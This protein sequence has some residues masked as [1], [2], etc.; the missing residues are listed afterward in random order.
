MHAFRL[1]FEAC[2][3]KLL[4]DSWIWVTLISSGTGL[5]SGSNRVNRGA[6]SGPLQLILLNGLSDEPHNAFLKCFAS[7]RA[8][9]QKAFVTIERSGLIRKSLVLERLIAGLRRI[10][11]KELVPDP[12]VEGWTPENVMQLGQEWIDAAIDA[13]PVEDVLS[14]Y[15][16]EDVL[17]RYKPEDVLSRYK[18]EDRVA[19][20]RPED[21][22]AGLNVME[23]M[24]GL[25][26][27]TIVLESR[28]EGVALMLSRL[29]KRRFDNLPA[30]V[31]DKIAK[32][33]L[34][35][36]EEWS[37]RVVEA[38]SLEDIFLS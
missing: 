9:C 28:R 12:E 26:E 3:E 11:M 19:G 24:A 31:S 17:S 22:L 18:P 25:S 8:E 29:L 13:M 38:Q 37:F 35:S 16:P 7:R 10:R 23:R 1:C 27:Q 4:R 2:W 32:A 30:W 36:L 34:P 5:K 21:R 15:K 14:R 33:D 20:L 6:W